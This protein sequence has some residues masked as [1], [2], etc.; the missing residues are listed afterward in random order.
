[1]QIFG[2]LL[3]MIVAELDRSFSSI[4]NPETRFNCWLLFFNPPNFELTG[5]LNILSYAFGFEIR[6]DSKLSIQLLVTLVTYFFEMGA[7]NLT[8][9]SFNDPSIL[10][11]GRTLDECFFTLAKT[12]SG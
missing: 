3:K 11:L 5:T 6:S 2:R 4:C 10:K 8:A 1:M 7:L 9:E 12:L